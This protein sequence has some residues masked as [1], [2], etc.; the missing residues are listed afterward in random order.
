MSIRVLI[1]DDEPLARQRIRKLLEGDPDVEVVGESV[2]GNET[3][4]A[5][6]QK[7][8]DLLFLDIQMPMLDG[9]GV[10]E[11]LGVGKMP[12]TIFVTAYD[13]YAIKAFDVHALDYLL[14]PFDRD[15]FRKALQRAK[16]Y[17]GRPQPP[18]VGK[19]L[20]SLLSE[21]RQDRKPLERVVIKSASRVFFL[22]TEEIDW[23]EAAGN[24]LRLHIGKEFHLLRE[25]MNSFEAKLDLSLFVRIHRS[26]IVN[27]ERIK[28][29]QPYFHGDYAVILKD[30]T[31]LTL[32]RSHRPKLQS[33]VGEAF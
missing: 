12:A 13:R 6:R 27:V 21:V 14:K 32:S 29:L 20:N 25:T 18:E 9:F 5:V 8:P 1:A 24:Y 23:I 28:E 15:R 33:L 26:Y 11:A 31:Q 16:S 4:A 19:K 3:V 7:N 30:G 22:R 2:D 10:L 17:L